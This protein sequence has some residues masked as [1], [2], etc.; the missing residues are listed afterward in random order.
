MV[1]SP[2]LGTGALVMGGPGFLFRP[3]RD[4]SATHPDFDVWAGARAGLAEDL[5][6]DG[7]GRADAAGGVE[8]VDEAGVGVA[9][10]LEI[11]RA[12]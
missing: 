9:D 6:D 7:A 10:Q 11:V 4:G 3:D 2:C 8:G 5:G 1:V 12:G